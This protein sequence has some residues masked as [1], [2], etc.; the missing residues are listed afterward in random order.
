M[1]IFRL[2]RRSSALINAVVSFVLISI[3]FGAIYKV[4]PDRSLSGATSGW[5]PS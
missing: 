1:P 4:L 2:A 3:L 5:E